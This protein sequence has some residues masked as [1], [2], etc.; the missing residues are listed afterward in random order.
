MRITVLIDADSPLA[1]V[2]SIA[3]VE[4]IWVPFFQSDT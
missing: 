2:F 1:K 4:R 3:L